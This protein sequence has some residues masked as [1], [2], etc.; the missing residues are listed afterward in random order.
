VV[1]S[2]NTTQAEGLTRGFQ[3]GGYTLLELL[4]RGGEGSV[5]SARDG[6]RRRIVAL[7]IIPRPPDDFAIG[8]VTRDFERQVHLIASLDHP[9]ILPL[10]EFDNSDAF[11]YFAMRYSSYGP[12]TRRLAQGPLSLADTLAMTAQI[13]AALTYLHQKGIVHR[14]LKPSNILLDS[15]GRASLADFGLAK[16]LA[17]QTMALHTGRGTGPYAPYEQHMLDM[18]TPQSDIYSLGVMVYEMLAG[19]LP[20]DGSSDLATLQLQKQE[21]LPDLRLA[22]PDMPPAV[23]AALRRLTAFNWKDRPATAA[24]AY[25][26]LAEAAGSRQTAAAISAEAADGALFAQDAHQLLR[27][28]VSG[29]QPETERFRMRLSNLAVIDA[30]YT[31]MGDGRQ[32]DEDSLFDAAVRRFMLRGAL[33]HDYRLDYWWRQVSPEARARACEQA[34]AVENETI[35]ARAVAR[36]LA[37]SETAAQPVSLQ[38]RTWRRLAELAAGDG[39]WT[40]RNQALQLLLHAMPTA[41]QWRPVGISEAADDALA[42]LA[43]ENSALSPLAARLIG[44]MRSETA[45][46]S[47]LNRQPQM[48]AA[49]LLDALIL[50]Y[51]TAGSLPG[52]V[53]LDWR[54]RVAGRR[55]RRQFLEDREGLSWSRALIG[56]LAGLLAAGMLLLGWF[57]RAAVQLQDILLEPYPVSGIVTIVEVTDESLAR[58]GRWDD[59]PRSRHAEL[60]QRLTA[61]G[62]GAIVFDVLF[63]AETADDAEMAAAM[64][65]AGNV[66]LPLLGQGDAFAQASGVAQYRAGIWPQTRLAQAAAGLGHAN[67]LHD[68]DGYAGGLALGAEIAG[69]PVASLALTAIQTDLGLDEGPLS[70]QDGWIEAAGRRI[71]V[72]PMADMSI[73]FAGPPAQAD[74]ATFRAVSYEAVLA[75]EAPADWLRDKIILIGV[76]A[77]AEPDRYLTPVGDGRPMYGVEILANSIESI[78]S[79]R[80]IRHAPPGVEA[81]IVLLIALITGLVCTRPWSGLALAGGMAALYFLLASLLFDAFSLALDLFFPLMGIGLS[82]VA[83]TGYRFSVEIRRRRLARPDSHQ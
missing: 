67:I 71:K 17:L 58:Y 9:H 4:G 28:G 44:Q 48:G 77:A 59:W 81:A 33:A 36:L 13:T 74:A 34:I 16:R 50:I 45:A 62:A 35:Q 52:S 40:R 57:D 15:Q 66:A 68:A 32:P 63:D 73:Y 41:D 22:V 37:E 19:R 20:W 80:F 31:Q 64:M 8:Q 26:L 11:F 10:Y 78:W 47:L 49:R 14:D 2:A 39:Q 27:Q 7:K 70:V 79:G 60:V 21:T 82:Y 46:Q 38:R 65:Q 18:I 25:K 5:W 42:A 24:A 53:P 55:I 6:R 83:V 61:A 3:L 72:G 29:W 12:L 75:G 23:S 76:T 1:E 30:A 69:K 43:A 51:Q 56:L 54:R